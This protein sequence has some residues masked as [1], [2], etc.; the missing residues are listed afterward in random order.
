MKI[1]PCE[2]CGSQHHEFLFEGRDRIF[3]IPGVFKIVKCPECGLLFINPQ[4]DPQELEKYYPKDYHESQS[5][6]FKEYSWLRRKVLEAYWGYPLC[7]GTSTGQKLFE[8]LV[9]LPFRWRYRNSIHYVERGRLLDIGCG[10]GTEL[11]KL[12][13]MGWE[14]YG[15]E[16]NQAASE[17]ARSEGLS[18]FTG[19][20]FEANFPDDSFD[21]VR[22]S[23]VLEHLTNP[24]QTL[25]EIKRIL[26]PQGRIYISI[27]HSRSLN[28]WLFG[29]K[30]FSLDIPRHLFSFSIVTIKRLT[31]SL[32]LKV[33]AIRFDS[34]TRTFL[35]SLQYRINGR[36]SEKTLIQGKQSIYES[37]ALRYLSRPFCWFVDRVRLGDLIHLE[38]MRT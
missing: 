24:R 36:D 17:R 26:R 25:A 13:K 1:I 15:V 30:W 7:P 3:G 20:L 16:V 10:N 23:F 19:D 18:V 8:R 32:G 38:I 5:V 4:P 27:H 28:Y 22:M 21:V 35:A 34:G 14:T 37:R 2:V 29:E 11:Y 33:K 31:S 6:R 9:F 12:K